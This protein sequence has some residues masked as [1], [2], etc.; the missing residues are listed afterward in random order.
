MIT[1]I[2][3]KRAKDITIEVEN[4]I[5]SREF[6]SI[7]DFN[8]FQENPNMKGRQALVTVWKNEEVIVEDAVLT[9]PLKAGLLL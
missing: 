3:E 6:N 1:I 9:L 5:S 8:G 2:V 4:G 7:D